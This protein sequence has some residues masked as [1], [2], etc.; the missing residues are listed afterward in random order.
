M[1]SHMSHG[2][3][4]SQNTP[5]TFAL[6]AVTFPAAGRPPCNP[7]RPGCSGRSLI[8]VRQQPAPL[9]TWSCRRP[10]SRA[11]RRETSAT[12]GQTPRTRKR[13]RKERQKAP[14]LP[15][16]APKHETTTKA[17][18]Q[19]RHVDLF[20]PQSSKT[21]PTD[22]RIERDPENVARRLAR[23]PNSRVRAESTERMQNL[24][25]MDGLHPKKTE[26]APKANLRTL[27]RIELGTV[28][29]NRAPDRTKCPRRPSQPCP[30]R[31]GT[32]NDP[33][34]R[35]HEL[36]CPKPGEV[37]SNKPN[38]FAQTHVLALHPGTNTKELRTD[39][40]E[41]QSRQ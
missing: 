37:A 8:R 12:R 1:R 16:R 40:P 41:P 27:A 19:G 4:P 24:C 17:H 7:C 36:G 5:T 14:Q 30:P 2:S 9:Q 31:K 6:K 39:R 32:A 15:A 18:R 35:P 26:T 38:A 29:A 28:P 20:G 34:T 25:C 11:Q 10:P 33:K 22:P 13:R 21:K 3:Y 23:P